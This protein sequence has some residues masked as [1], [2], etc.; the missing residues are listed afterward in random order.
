MTDP[1]LSTSPELSVM[2]LQ[3]IANNL[4]NEKWKPLGRVLGLAERDLDNIVANPEH[5]DPVEQR[6]QMLL[7]WQHSQAEEATWE[8]LAKA[9]RSDDVGCPHLARRYR[10]GEIKPGVFVCMQMHAH[11]VIA[12]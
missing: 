7:L 5:H 10:T 3:R 4:P 8:K 12:F 9:L 2:D 1:Q 6:Y 11:T